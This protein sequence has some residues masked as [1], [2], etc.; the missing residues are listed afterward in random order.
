[1][2]PKIL[3]FAAIISAFT[4]VLFGCCKDSATE[5]SNPQLE[6]IAD[7]AQNTNRHIP[8]EVA[9]SSLEKF[10]KNNSQ[11]TRSNALINGEYNVS[12]VSIDEPT[13][14]NENS[15]GDI[16]YCID[17]HNDGGSAILSANTI[18]NDPIICVTENG[19]IDAD[20]ISQTVKQLKDNDISNRNFTITE[21]TL[22]EPE[23][24]II[25]DMISDYLIASISSGPVVS[26][27]DNNSVENRYGP[28]IMTNWGQNSP[29]DIRMDGRTV[30]CV[31][32]AVAQ[33]MLY[34]QKQ[35]PS[36]LFWGKGCSWESMLKVANCDSTIAVSAQPDDVK[37]VAYYLRQLHEDCNITRD[38]TG[39]VFGA[40]RALKKYGFS[41]T[42]VRFAVTSL[43]PRGK[44]HLEDAV[45]QIKEGRPVPVFAA[46]QK[47][48]GH[49]FVLDGFWTRAEGDY[50]HINWG[51]EG[52]GN[53]YFAYGVFQELDR[54]YID[55]IDNGNIVFPEIGETYHNYN[56]DRF[57][58][59]LFYENN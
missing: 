35:L 2:R 19:N 41:D 40:K 1:M 43:G 9:M 50:F 37:Q 24:K 57:I 33:T 46:N 32:V 5:P 22:I 42:K 10:L 17:F 45:Q 7:N 13:R 54:E 59:Y 4:L 53:G 14:S 27:N 44:K 39:T 55:D 48:E 29:F 30:G 12:I 3:V 26:N 38:G 6:Q 36:M 52:D 11:P 25:E 58:Y 8:L 18:I 51:W 47:C 16:L 21:N 15:I 56:F 20:A 31:T 28:Y 23:P 49:A 34:F